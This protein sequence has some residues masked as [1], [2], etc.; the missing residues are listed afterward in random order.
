MEK[1]VGLSEYFGGS[2]SREIQTNGFGKV[3]VFLVVVQIYNWRIVI[4]AI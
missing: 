4:Y 2:D 3:C 1:F